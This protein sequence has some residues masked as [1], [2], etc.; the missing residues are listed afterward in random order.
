MIRCSADARLDKESIV[1]HCCRSIPF[2]AR[3]VKRKELERR[4]TR[5]SLI[6]RVIVSVRGGGGH[7]R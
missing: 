1:K 5:A 2:P 6:T 7:W 4:K 3:V